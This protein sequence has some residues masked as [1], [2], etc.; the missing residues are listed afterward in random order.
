MVEYRDG[1][2]LAH[3]GVPDMKI[4]IGYCLTYP[5]RIEHD[6]DH[7]DF[8]TLGSLEFEKP[9]C[10]TFPCLD[11]AFKALASGP[12]YPVVLNA[13]NEVAVQ[14]FLDG[15]IPFLGIAALV[16]AA[17]HWH[18]PEPVDSLE[19]ILDLDA[20]T[21]AFATSHMATGPQSFA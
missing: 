6:L 4:P 21:R 17:L 14:A 13:A 2:I 9:R 3:M 20:S 7:L 10:D 16:E 8:A 12:S 15:K 19:D 5:Q 11:L 18:S 1:S